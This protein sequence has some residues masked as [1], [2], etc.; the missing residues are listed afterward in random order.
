MPLAYLAGAAINYEVVGDR[1][2]W[3]ALISRGLEP[4]GDFG[5]LARDI[6]GGGCRVLIHDRRNC[7]R[8]SFD[9]DNAAPDEDVWADDL[10]ALL[11]H[12]GAAP[13]IVVGWS[14]GSRVAI[15]LALRHPEAACGLVL[16]GLSGGPV[17]VRFLEEFYFLRHM[18]AA[19]QGGMDAVS[20]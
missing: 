14:R 7:G 10:A 11:R 1:G 9:L 18:R 6:A 3:I 12:V 4:L 2:P 17:A 13:A 19:E 20:A 15:R 16:W 5:S 8:S